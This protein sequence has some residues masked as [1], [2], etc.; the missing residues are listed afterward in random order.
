MAEDDE[1]VRRLT[2]GKERGDTA[3]ERAPDESDAFVPL[4]SQRVACRAK[5]SISER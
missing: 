5:S 2:L 1:R 4:R 3:A